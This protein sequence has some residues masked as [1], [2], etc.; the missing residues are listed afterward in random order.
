MNWCTISGTLVFAFLLCA[1]GDTGQNTYPLRVEGA[2]TATG[3]FAV[4]ARLP[5]DCAA[6]CACEDG[7]W[8]VTIERADVAFGPIYLCA[9][10]RASADLCGESVAEM[11]DVGIIDAT[12]PAPVLLGEGL[13]FTG[14][15]QS[16]MW[17]YGRSWLLTQTLV[18]PDPIAPGGHSLVLR[19]TATKGATSFRFAADVDINASEAGL[20]GVQS[21]PV[22][23]D[24]VGPFEAL[25]VQID[26]AAWV[27]R[28]E[29]DAVAC[30]RPSVSVVDVTFGPE[31]IPYNALYGAMTNSRLP[32][33]VGQSSAAP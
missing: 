29:F 11:L 5:P 21:A 17:D 4:A 32:A 24:F 8:Q 19:G 27:S 9:S 13:A 33:I 31:S 22:A 26:A 14:R 3:T 25:R 6:P 2:G 10:E 15:A 7:D 28:I 20:Y 16:A 12:D 18:K 1:C 23:H 30:G